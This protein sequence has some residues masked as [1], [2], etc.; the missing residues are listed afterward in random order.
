[1]TLTRSG[2]DPRELLRAIDAFATGRVATDVANALGLRAAKLVQRGFDTSRAPDGSPWRPLA[3]ST[4]RGR[5]RRP[6]RKTDA[7]YR[8]ATTVHFTRDGFYLVSTY[9]GSYHQ[10]EA[11]RSRLPRR[12]FFPDESGLSVGWSIELRD[13]ADEAL[14]R[15]VP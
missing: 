4:T 7:L 11:P 2:D 6:L 8:S 1:M 10:S 5:S 3:A 14:R 12:P 9:P 13:A 15:W